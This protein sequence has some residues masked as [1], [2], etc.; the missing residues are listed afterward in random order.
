MDDFQPDAF[1][2]Y[3]DTLSPSWFSGGPIFQKLIHT[4]GK[5]NRGAASKSSLRLIRLPSGQLDLQTINELEEFFSAQIIE[6]YSS[7]ETG[8]ISANPLTPSGCRRGTVGV[9]I[10]CNV[11]IRSLHGTYPMCGERGEVVV[12]SPILFEGY[13]NDPAANE[14]AFVDGWFR[15]GDEGFLDEDGYLTLT[16]RIK[17]MINRGGEKVSPAE[18][19]A[20]LMGHPDVREAAT[21]PIPHPTL[22]EEVGAVVVSEANSGLSANDLRIYLVGRISG[23]KMPKFI[24]L[25]EE[26]PKSAAGKVQR[27][28]LAETFGVKIGAT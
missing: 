25:A 17:E 14:E 21:F 15:T 27:H 20:A 8:L 4:Y 5:A 1:F 9:P 22:G 19:D 11:R 6:S 7:S 10:E 3:L 2:R 24:V 13:E 28:K 26:I 16:G 18:V 23:F 12:R